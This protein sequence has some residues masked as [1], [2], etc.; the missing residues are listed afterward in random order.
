MIK[1]NVPHAKRKGLLLRQKGRQFGQPSFFMLAYDLCQRN[2][3]DVKWFPRYNAIHALMSMK[4]FKVPFMQRW[5]RIAFV[6]VSFTICLNCSLTNNLQHQNTTI[7]RIL[8]CKFIFK[9]YFQEYNGA[10]KENPCSQPCSDFAVDMAQPQCI[11]IVL[12][13][14]VNRSSPWQILVIICGFVA[15]NLICNLF[16]RVCEL[17]KC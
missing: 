13:G 3:S 8:K 12:Q 4:N 10:K 2:N 16:W 6:I 11:L 15:T 5:F 9:E 17:S 14:T 7:E 1:A